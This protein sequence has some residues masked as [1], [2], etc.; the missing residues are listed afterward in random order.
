MKKKHEYAI[1][2]VLWW[3]WWSWWLIIIIVLLSSSRD[4]NKDG[5]DY[6]HDIH[7]NVSMRFLTI[8]CRWNTFGGL[9]Q[10]FDSESANYSNAENQKTILSVLRILA[11]KIDIIEQ[12]DVFNINH[13]SR[14][15]S[16]DD[17]GNISESQLI[18]KKISS[19]YRLSY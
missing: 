17:D 2:V 7:A 10:Y 12:F 8:R 16:D 1:E 6:Y 11:L 18:M 5:V 4:D 9:H 3:W 14:C 19:R 13:C 15:P